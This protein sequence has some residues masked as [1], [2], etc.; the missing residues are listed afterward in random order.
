[1]ADDNKENKENKSNT[2]DRIFFYMIVQLPGG[3]R[4]TYR[5][6]NDLYHALK[7]QMEQN[8]EYKSILTDALINVPIY[9]SLNYIKRTYS[10]F[11][12]PGRVIKVF[13][14]KWS[15]R[16]IC[17]SQF[18]SNDNIDFNDKK[19]LRYLQ[20]DYSLLNKFAIRL[21]WKYWKFHYNHRKKNSKW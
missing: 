19:Q 7:Q 3:K 21:C 20:H 17:R 6:T 8:N 1:M 13:H 9:S 14:K 5:T 16:W 18:I 12:I 2:K 10:S 11:T 4:L 15:S